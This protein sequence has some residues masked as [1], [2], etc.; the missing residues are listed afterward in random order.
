MLNSGA[1]KLQPEDPFTWTSGATM[2]VYNDNRVLLGSFDN[3]RIVAQAFKMILQSENVHPNVIAGTA[4]AGIAPATSLAD[5]LELPLVY[6]R[7]KAKGHGLQ[8]RIEGVLLPG[9]DVVLVE[10][11]ISTGG[12]AISAIEAIR[13]SGGNV[14]LCLAI[15]SY[16]FE[17]AQDAFAD[18][19]CPIRTLLTFDELR[20]IAEKSGYIT[21]SQNTMLSD[22]SK[23]PF[24]WGRLHGYNPDQ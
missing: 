8:K 5:C 12:S 2:P 4:T 15:F 24:D 13:E 18:I 7:G 21:S 23:A 19:D 9:Q 6:V 22:W 10:D 14:K 16:G 11:L 17:K 3:R 20:N 1:T